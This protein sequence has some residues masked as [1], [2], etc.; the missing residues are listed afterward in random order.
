VAHLSKAD[1]NFNASKVEPSGISFAGVRSHLLPR[2]LEK[3]LI[4]PRMGRMEFPA[5]AQ[6]MNLNLRRG[7]PIC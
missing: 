1:F 6:L 3:A 7:G 5:R 4:T 2:P